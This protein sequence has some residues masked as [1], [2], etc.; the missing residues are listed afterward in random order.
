MSEELNNLKIHIKQT[1][2]KEKNAIIDFGSKMAQKIE[3][4]FKRRSDKKDYVINKLKT[5]SENEI[6]EAESI[7]R[8]MTDKYRH[9]QNENSDLE[10]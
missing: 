4:E 2:T 7:L 10:S 9:L 3:L 1:M 5:Q 6:I 8:N